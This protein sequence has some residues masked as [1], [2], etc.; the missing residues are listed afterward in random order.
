VQVRRATAAA[1]SA[2]N[3][4]L[5]EGEIGLE[6]DTGKFKFGDGSTAWTSLPYATDPSR[7]PDSVQGVASA[8]A[9]G[10][11]SFLPAPSND[12]SGATD[13][14]AINAVLAGGGHIKPNPLALSATY[15]TD[16]PLTLPSNTWLDL[17]AMTVITRAFNEHSSWTIENSN[18]VVDRGL[19]GNTNIMITGGQFTVSNSTI[20]GG[21]I[22]LVGVSIA[23]VRDVNITGCYGPG[24]TVCLYN[25][26]HF[27]VMDNRVTNQGGTGNDG[28]HLRA[29]NTGTVHHNIVDSGDD[30]LA[31]GQ[32]ASSEPPSFNITVTGN[33]L[34]SRASPIKLY[35]KGGSASTVSR[36]TASGNTL[37]TTPGSSE[38]S[39]S[40]ISIWDYTTAGGGI[41]DSVIENFTVDQQIDG[42][43]FDLWGPNNITIKNG[44]TTPAS[45]TTF[46]SMSHVGGVTSSGG[47]YATGNSGANSS[48]VVIED[49]TWNL[50]VGTVAQGPTVSYCT[51]FSFRSCTII[52]TNSAGTALGIAPYGPVANGV[53][54]NNTI[55]TAGIGISLGSTNGILASNVIVTKNTLTS[56]SVRSVVDMHGSHN[57]I[58]DDNVLVGSPVIVRQVPTAAMS[59]RF[60]IS[61]VAISGD[62]AGDRCGVIT[63]TTSASPA[64]GDMVTLTF[65]SP[66]TAT[67][68]IGLT[69]IG[70][71]SASAL[72]YASNSG[73]VSFGSNVSGFL[74]G[75]G[76][77][78]AARTA[79]SYFYTVTF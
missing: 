52:N 21:H 68:K 32:E 47:G 30:A 53:V 27:K 75:F 48:N 34:S 33:V 66:V 67:P 26:D 17:D 24:W 39:H 55:D 9:S 19:V 42:L 7:L 13:T 20:V 6:T 11:T 51:G 8:Y 1:A 54:E 63:I 56:C 15:Y 76:T 44:K 69:P 35:T 36:I 16:A 49:V 31:I 28:I 2:S 5:A 22:G 45:P 65:H 74:M 10:K 64:S 4:I 29:C 73:P 71:A 57:L 18:K 23:T 60:A 25:C 77:V 72:V 70:A 41:L 37:I 40:V 14:E 43:V 38:D 3:P 79:L 50:P 46:S 78:P 12:T 62:S 61:A 58:K 59:N